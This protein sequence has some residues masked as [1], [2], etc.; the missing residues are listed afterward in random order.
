MS[1]NGA[2][3]LEFGGGNTKIDP[4]VA[5]SEFRIVKSPKS[6]PH[7]PLTQGQGRIDIE[8]ADRTQVRLSRDDLYGQ[9]ISDER[10]GGELGD[11]RY[12][13]KDMRWTLD[14]PR[15]RTP[16]LTRWSRSCSIRVYLVSS[17]PLESEGRSGKRVACAR[18]PLVRG[19][20]RR[21]GHGRITRLRRLQLLCSQR[22]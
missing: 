11:V 1:Y 7:Q 12:F 2:E 10:L 20:R 17:A 13:A 22:I 8:L 5:G 15:D 18:R 14:L 9:V 21:R 4:T 3:G 6:A 16:S 19:F